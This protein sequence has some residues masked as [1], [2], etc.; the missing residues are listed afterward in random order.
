MNRPLLL[1]AR[2]AGNC[3]SKRKITS[4]PVLTLFTKKDC[5]LC[6]EAKETL[7]KHF[8]GKY[9]LEEID[10]TL[11]ENRH[12]FRKYK[13]DIPVFYFNNELFMKH[14]IDV[15]SVARIIQNT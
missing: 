9:V 6:E 11:P 12:W 5:S 3:C 14:K 15:A 4:L 1:L 13:Y 10:I 8:S 2:S 7:A